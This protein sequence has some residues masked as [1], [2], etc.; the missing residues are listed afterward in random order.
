MVHGDPV[1][2]AR[3]L[4]HHS[5]SMPLLGCCRC[6]DDGARSALYGE[7]RG[8]RLG[9]RFC[10]SANSPGMVLVAAVALPMLPVLHLGNHL[11]TR[12]TLAAVAWLGCLP[13]PADRVSSAPGWSHRQ[14]SGAVDPS[15]EHDMR[16][17]IAAHLADPVVVRSASGHPGRRG[18]W[19]RQRDP[20]TC[21]G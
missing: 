4:P 12:R 10:R 11:S 5:R 15:T 8:L 16:R 3:R 18:S 9:R 2:Q 7:R 13:F 14:R 19:P 17:A 20:R 1:S 6:S 21:L